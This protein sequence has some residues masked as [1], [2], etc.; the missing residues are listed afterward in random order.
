MDFDKFLQW[1]H[2]PV[3]DFN[4]QATSTTEELNACGNNTQTEAYADE[5]IT[6]RETLVSSLCKQMDFDKILQ[7]VQE[8]TLEFKD[9][10]IFV[11]EETQETTVQDKYTQTEALANDIFTKSDT[12]VSSCE[13]RTQTV[14]PRH[15]L[16]ARGRKLFAAD[17]DLSFYATEIDKGKSG[18]NSKRE[19]LDGFDGGDDIF[20]K[21]CKQVQMRK[22][23]FGVSQEGDNVSKKIEAHK[24]N[25][26]SD[27]L[28][29]ATE[30]EQSSPC[31]DT[32]ASVVP[33]MC[34]G[35]LL[36]LSIRSD[37]L[38]TF[39]IAKIPE[40]QSTQEITQS[41]LLENM[42]FRLHN[43]SIDRLYCVDNCESKYWNASISVNFNPSQ[44]LQPERV[45]LFGKSLRMFSPYSPLQCFK[46]NAYGHI[47]KNCLSVA[48]CRKCSGEHHHS[49][50]TASWRACI[51]C[52]REKRHDHQ[53]STNYGGCKVR[54]ERIEHE[55][56]LKNATA[57]QQSTDKCNNEGFS[58][59]QIDLKSN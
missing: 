8:P 11:T 28:F 27:K 31:K 37:N 22:S 46:C 7:W 12:I 49:T 18:R 44:F 2:E 14:T 6:T 58:F 9:Q 5:E 21:L 56:R 26:P 33:K 57:S 32:T 42:F 23:N 34:M 30:I 47:A 54:I 48:F 4:D 52:L 3:R 24:F 13:K 25:A 55:L 39:T 1:V 38:T 20:N 59:N 41:L 53:H 16:I 43:F 40:T 35:N 29:T 15:E 45:N 50:C 17:P 51:N 36:N 10:A 19:L